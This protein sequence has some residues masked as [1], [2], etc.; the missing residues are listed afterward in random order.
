MR[1]LLFITLLISG[2]VGSSEAG[3]AFFHKAVAAL[4]VVAP[5]LEID[6]KEI[7]PDMKEA[8]LGKQFPNLALECHEEPSNLGDRVCWDQ[9]GWMNNLPADHV[10]FFLRSRPA[11]AH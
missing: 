2:C 10:A 11:G 8:D 7:T 3:N 6:F 9:I 1:K 5:Y 4:P